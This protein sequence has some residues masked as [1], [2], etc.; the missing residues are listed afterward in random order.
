MT[1]L[2]DVEKAFEKTQP[3]VPI[4]V[5]NK[6]VLET[7]STNLKSIYEK[8]TAYIM[9]NGEGLVPSD[10]EQDRMSTFA[11]F[12]PHCTRVSKKKK[13]SSKLDTSKIGIL[14]PICMIL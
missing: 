8:S 11:S 9:L 5:H 6:L 10:Q 12:S 3:S 1:I 14:T 13:K 2:I 7:Y 4:K